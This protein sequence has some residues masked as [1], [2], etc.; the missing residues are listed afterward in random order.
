MMSA[1]LPHDGFGPILAEEPYDQMGREFR[2]IFGRWID[3]TPA[4]FP[5]Q[6]ASK[7]FQVLVFDLFARRLALARR[8]QTFF[9]T[10]VVS[11]DRALWRERYIGATNGHAYS[12]AIRDLPRTM[13]FYEWCE[14]VTEPA[15]QERMW[16]VTCKPLPQLP[17]APHTF[18]HAMPVWAHRHEPQFRARREGA[19]FLRRIRLNTT[20]HLIEHP[21]NRWV[22]VLRQ[23]AQEHWTRSNQLKRPLSERATHLA[24]FEWLW[25]WLNP[26][27]RAGAL[28]GDAMSLLAQKQ[29]MLDGLPAHI[30]PGYYHQDCE[31][32]LLTEDT[33]VAK[34]VRDLLGGFSPMFDM[35]VL[36]EVGCAHL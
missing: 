4:R 27:G 16:D 22:P 2:D 24:Q 31:A 23:E 21:D 10:Q 14:Q 26:F 32:F 36:K 6:T 12:F 1:T 11:G 25:F 13:R 19:H 5:D 20:V 15:N 7:H 35:A 33:Y 29:M 17:L 3:D 28:T 34:R 30:R 9:A 18:L 8:H